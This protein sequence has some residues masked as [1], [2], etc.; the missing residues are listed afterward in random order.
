MSLAWNT[1]QRN[2]LAS[3]SADRT[4]KLWDLTTQTCLRTYTHHTDKVSSVEWNP[5]EPAVLLTGSFDRTAQVRSGQCVCVCVCVC[6]I[7]LA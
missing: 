1:N 5:V 7:D 4:V 3:G 2:L 6:T